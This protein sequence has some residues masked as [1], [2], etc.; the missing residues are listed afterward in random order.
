MLVFTYVN[1][2]FSGYKWV[3]ERRN[4]IFA[5]AVGI[6]DSFYQT[7]VFLQIKQGL[8][9]IVKIRIRNYLRHSEYYGKKISWTILNFLLIVEMEN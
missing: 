8:Q 9:L 2:V 5:C 3:I 4:Y 1:E 7:L 6:L